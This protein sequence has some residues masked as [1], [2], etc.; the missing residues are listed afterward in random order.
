VDLWVGWGVP[1]E[2]CIVVKP[3]DVV[4]VKDI[5]IHAF[6]AFD[7]PALIPLPADQKAAGV[8]PDGMDV[9]AVNYLFKTPGGNLYHSGDSHYSN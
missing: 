5:E 2:R 4:K 1:K 9:R 3:G 6:D 8:L 7:R